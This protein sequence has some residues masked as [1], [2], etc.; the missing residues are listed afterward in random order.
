MTRSTVKKLEEPLDEPERELH[1][2]RKAVSQQQRNESLAIARRNL[3]DDETSSVIN[4]EVIVTPPI[5]SLREAKRWLDRIPSSQ[6]TTWEQLVSKFLDKFLPPGRTSI[7]R[8][9]ILQFCQIQIFHDN[10][11]PDDHGRLDQF[12]HFH[13]SLLSEEEGW[14]R[15]EEYVCIK[16]THGM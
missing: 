4:T 13:F 12:T 6:I 9:T 15:I 10:I 1:R 14:N 11:S 16:M 3:F 5:K 8:D 7:I 2:R